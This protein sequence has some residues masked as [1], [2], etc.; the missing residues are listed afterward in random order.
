MREGG[1]GGEKGAECGEGARSGERVGVG[2]KGGEGR[3]EV[4]TDPVSLC[5]GAKDI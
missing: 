4:W 2:Q 3:G 5:S 1:K